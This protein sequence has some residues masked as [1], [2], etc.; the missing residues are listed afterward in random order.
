[1]LELLLFVI[2]SALALA[3]DAF[4][5]SI[6]NG[7]VY[8]DLN[9]RKIVLM[10]TIYGLFQALMPILG[11]YVGA[12]IFPYIQ[13]YYRWIALLLLVFIG[14]K[15][16]FD[17]IRDL[18]KP[19][20][21]V[22]PKKFSFWEVLIQGVATSIDALAVGFTLQ[23]ELENVT[24]AGFTTDGAAWFSVGIIGLIT[25]ILT[26]VGVII[27]TKV[28]KLLKNKTSIAQ[29]IGGVVLILIGIKIILGQYV[30]ALA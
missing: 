1:M 22:E 15:M 28:G 16:I 14:G 21:E 3:I 17:A 18:R 27:G 20:E 2:P 24:I 10:P 13:D 12:I 25:F 9:K 23:G 19:P 6:T 4:S 29:I 8:T 11:Y 5:A 26:L 7:M 30:P